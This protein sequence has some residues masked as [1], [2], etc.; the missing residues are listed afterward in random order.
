METS[1]AACLAFTQAEEGGYVTD[2]RDSGNWTGGRVGQGSLIGSNM[3]VGAP[4]LTAWMG[5]G[6]QVTAEQMRKLPLT[7]ARAIARN[8]YWTPLGCET[9]SA[10]VDL[11]LFDFGWNRGI[12]TSLNVLIRCLG[13]DRQ[14]TE[15]LTPVTI[16][17]ALQQIPADVMLQQISAD[18]VRILQRLLGIA[19]DGI[20]GA[21]T[22]KAFSEQPGLRA[23]AIILAISKAQIASYRVLANFPLYGAGWLARSARRQAAAISVT[24]QA[25]NHH[26]ASSEDHRLDHAVPS[27]S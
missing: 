18:G 11:M 5:P 26:L 14:W 19:D 22:L 13:M 20:A 21:E 7:T 23:V 25:A 9:I 16:D 10:G 17:N 3:G 2:R 1:F 4:A 15:P 8:R 12:M 24:R 6:V 27:T